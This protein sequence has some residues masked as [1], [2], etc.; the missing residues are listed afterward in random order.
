MYLIG[1]LSPMSGLGL[2]GLQAMMIIGM[3]YPK[4][5]IARGDEPQARHPVDGK[6]QQ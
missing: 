4:V 5:M 6:Y 3:G 1:N 2:I